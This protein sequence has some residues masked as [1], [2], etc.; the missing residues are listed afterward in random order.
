MVTGQSK[1]DAGPP[2]PSSSPVEFFVGLGD[3]LKQAAELATRSA[4]LMLVSSD[5]ELAA[6]I[7]CPPAPRCNS[8]AFEGLP[9]WHEEEPVC[10]FAPQP[11]VFAF[12]AYSVIEE[13]LACPPAPQCNVFA[14][15]AYPAFEEDLACPP[16]PQCNAFAFEACT[17]WEYEPV[18]PSAPQP[19]VW[20]FEDLP[21]PSVDEEV[22]GAGAAQP[23]AVEMVTCE[24]WWVSRP[25][26]QPKEPKMCE[27][28]WVR[29]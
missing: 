14:F 20:A 3:M 15:E 10:P 4:S 5:I 24:A 13:D 27:A 22:A 23:D 17:E 2:I 25:A 11:N 26:P 8:F 18:C 28:W 19:N 16:T 1:A 12:E 7:E 9:S 6:P 29:R 21:S